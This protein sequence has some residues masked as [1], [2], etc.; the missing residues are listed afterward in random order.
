MKIETIKI[1][2]TLIALSASL[3]LAVPRTQ[4]ASIFFNASST[5]S[6]SQDFKVDIIVDPEGQNLNAFEGEMVFPTSLI[7]IERIN[8]GDSIVNFWIDPPHAAS[9]SDSEAGAIAWSGITPGGFQE[10][11]GIN[12]IKTGKL[13][14]VVF[15]PKKEGIAKINAD[16]IK[17]LL[18]DGLGTPAKVS[19]KPISL[20]ITSQTGAT[21][22]IAK[23]IN[24]PEEFHP[25]VTN[26]PSIFNNQYFLVF[27]ADDKES[28]I[29]HYEVL[30]TWFGKAPSNADWI[31]AESPYLIKN[32]TLGDYIL[33]KAVDKSGNYRIETVA[34]IH[35]EVRYEYYFLWSIIILGI[36][37][38]G[39][40]LWKKL[41]RK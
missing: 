13:F 28:G 9:S 21:A 10:N 16:N 19:V 32:Q 6:V 24:P 26:D 37:I 39:S 14:S 33:V 27:A 38:A 18:G 29:D 15:S 8:D 7:K 30:E 5:V 36:L 23:D 1:H 2:L 40:L 11:S 20:N 4:A 35:P 17:I 41:K 31:T 34:P 3:F 22:T 25:E 12:S